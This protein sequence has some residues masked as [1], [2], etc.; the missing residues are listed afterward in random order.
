M[1]AD[2]NIECVKSGLTHT[3]FNK[4]EDL[5]S[6]L[7]IFFGDADI[8]KESSTK[9]NDKTIVVFHMK[10]KPY[11]AV[12]DY[13]FHL[14]IGYESRTNGHSGYTFANAITEVDFIQ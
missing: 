13:D 8:T 7:A 9:E 12:P 4:E 3:L 6:N 11:L 1:R 10:R 2:Q 5:A 14:K